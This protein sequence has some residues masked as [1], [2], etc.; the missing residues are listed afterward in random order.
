VT[1]EARAVVLV[2]GV[3]V[4]WGSVGVVVLQVDLP[5]V[6]IVAVRAGL[7]SAALGLWLAGR[8][9]RPAGAAVLRHQPWRTVLNGLVLAAHWVTFIAALQRA[10]IGNVLLVVYLAPVG[11][12]VLAPRVLG[13]RVPVRTVVALGLALGGIALV[14]SRTAAVS[15]DGLWLAAASSALYVWLA[16]LNK[17]LSSAYGGARLAFIQL[18]VAAV[19][20]APAAVVAG[21]GAPSWS[22]AWLLV[23]GLGHTALCVALYLTALERLPAS[24]VAVLLYLE[25]VSALLFG[26]LLLSESPG[27]ATLAGGLL[28]VAA[29]VLVARPAAVPVPVP[30]QPEVAGVPR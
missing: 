19:V 21:A 29:G 6:T 14:A 10:P 8:E 24:R 2:V 22:W 20:L 13:E 25:P 11:I 9:R 5:A 28:V 7:A 26:W 3:A 23:L 1:S 17:P 30:S 15:A 16:L 12:A 18:L 4:A 27:R